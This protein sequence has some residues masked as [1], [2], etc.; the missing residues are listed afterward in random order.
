MDKQSQLMEETQT[1]IRVAEPSTGFDRQPSAQL[2]IGQTREGWEL[3]CLEALQC[4]ACKQVKPREFDICPGERN[5]ELCAACI[6][7]RHAAHG[8]HGPG[9]VVEGE[10]VTFYSQTTG[11]E[12]FKVADICRVFPGILG[13]NSVF[14]CCINVMGP[15]HYPN[16]RVE[17][18]SHCFGVTQEFSDWLVSAFTW[19]KKP[20]FED[21]EG[22]AWERQIATPASRP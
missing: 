9:F 20:L 22:E 3:E 1:P 13:D 5:A 10:W 12:H 18:G 11:M 7:A 16:G 21:E 17:W 14:P 8:L 19:T 15:Q 6:R 2:Q 4:P